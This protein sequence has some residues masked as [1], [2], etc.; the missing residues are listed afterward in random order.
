[1]K[2]SIKFDLSGVTY[3]APVAVTRLGLP[4]GEAA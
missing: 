1:M 3:S 2:P 4:R